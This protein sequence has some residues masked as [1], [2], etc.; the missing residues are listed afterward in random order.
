MARITDF[1]DK[2]PATAIQFLNITGAQHRSVSQR[3]T[4]PT[5]STPQYLYNSLADFEACSTTEK[6]MRAPGKLAYL[7]EGVPITGDGS[8]AVGGIIGR[9]YM[10]FS[11]SLSGPIDPDLNG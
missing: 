8:V 1:G 4:I 3:A 5:F 9:I 10:E 2:E 6:N 11:P 7:V